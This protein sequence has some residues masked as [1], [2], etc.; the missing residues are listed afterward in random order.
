MSIYQNSKLK[1][2]Y[3]ENRFASDNDAVKQ[4]AATQG[5]HVAQTIHTEM[6]W[7]SFVS[8]VMDRSKWKYFTATSTEEYERAKANF[9]A[10]VFAEML[11]GAARSASNVIA[12]YALI[13]D[14]DNGISVQ[15]AMQDLS[16]YEYVLYSSGGTGIKSGERFRIVLPLA[17]T[18]SA[19]EWAE[20]SETL[21]KRF[22]YSD[23]SFSKSLQIQYLPTYNNAHADSFIAHHNAGRLLDVMGELEYV[24]PL[25]QYINVLAHVQYEFS[26]TELAD[27]LN[28]IVEHNRGQMEYEE[29]RKLANRLAALGVTQFDMVQVLEAVGRPGATHSG[30]DM[31]SMANASYGHIGGLRKNL[32][33]GYKLPMPVLKP[34]Y[35][36]VKPVIAERCQ[37]DYELWL[38]AD[39]YL[40]DVV[41][42][43]E[44]KPGINM[45]IVDCSAGKSFYW[46]QV[47]D[48]LMAAPL[49][50]IVTQNTRKGAEV[51][52]LEQ[53]V[54]TYQQLQKILNKTEDHGKYKNMVLVIDEAHGLYLD[55]FKDSTNKLVHDCFSLFK[56]VVLMS[57]TIRREYFSNLDVVNTIR[58]HKEQTFEK[59]LHRVYCENDIIGVASERIRNSNNKMVIWL[60]DKNNIDV[61]VQKC[62]NKRF[63]VITAD[64]KNTEAVQAFYKSSVLNDEYDAVIGTNSIVEGMNINDVLPVCEVHVIGDC[65]P[66]RVEQV[67]NRWRKCTGTIRT[68]HYTDAVI[69]DDVELLEPDDYIAIAEDNA[70]AMN[71]YLA[72]LNDKRRWEYINSFSRENRFE[73]VYWEGQKIAVSYTRVDFEMSEN[74]AAKAR[75]EF[76]Y[77]A[78]QLTSY[79]FKFTRPERST[80]N[81]DLSTERAAIR[82]A[83][84]RQHEETIDLALSQ[85]QDGT[86]FMVV[87]EFDTPQAAVQR[88]HVNKF[89]IRGLSR[90]DVPEYLKRLRGDDLYWQRLSSD[91]QARNGNIVRDYLLEQLPLHLVTY[92]KDQRQGLTSQS[93]REL[94]EKIAR[95]VL[96]ERFNGDVVRM[97]L[98][99]WGSVLQNDPRD[100]SVSYNNEKHV[101]HLLSADDK[102]PDAVLS[103]YIT[104][105][106]SQRPRIN[107]KAE[108]VNAVL[109]TSLTGFTFEP[110]YVETSSA[111]DEQKSAVLNFL[112]K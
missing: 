65:T 95:F 24:Q 93:K 22:W 4:K 6:E 109:H 15:D 100:F 26:Q 75:G 45:M 111:N 3:F 39:Q 27:L 9:D 88:Q 85:W 110:T 56:S 77:Y 99:G 57:G 106:K 62:P 13:L 96:I 28:A 63:L 94:A 50:S 90:S 108:R 58:V 103:R 81:I 68:T 1:L 80:V 67:T 73:N 82:D 101:D 76:E 5:R 89:V 35:I 83:V 47:P 42:Q 55:G 52:N 10:V 87:D 60:N 54:G 38:K 70:R 29:R 74:R 32:P 107:G 71:R 72:V 84:R 8:D 19:G 51:N 14:I 105:D 104:L 78:Q 12:H 34:Q 31:A 30:N 49:L 102:A 18:L 53:G 23:E 43:F 46:S 25:P 86:G 59:V 112:K 16:Q 69:W 21:K 37:Y 61:V 11:P 91:L 44:I 64:T 48:A 2:T 66:E 7:G 40:S 79:G 36:D 33:H 17:K 97:G 98:A 92:G 20:W 41:D